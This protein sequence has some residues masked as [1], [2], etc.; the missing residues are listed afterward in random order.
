MIPTFVVNRKQPGTQSPSAYVGYFA[1]D[2]DS[3]SLASAVTGHRSTSPLQ[4][5][6]PSI[7]VVY[8]N[9][10]TNKHVFDTK[11]ARMKNLHQGWNGYSA[12]PPTNR[13]I[14]TARY[15]VE[16]LV[17]NGQEPLRVAPSVIG[18]VGV[19]RRVADRKVYVEFYNEGGV[20]ALFS[21]GVTEPSAK[22]V[23]PNYVGFTSLIQEMRD[24]LDGRTS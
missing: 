21:D 6:P 11:F 10:Q 12:P 7:R 20:V 14:V 8:Q 9:S 19:T 18:G 1:D 24:Y 5:E 2:S 22:E 15:F 16:L 17:A 4:S 23:D 13:A 3:G